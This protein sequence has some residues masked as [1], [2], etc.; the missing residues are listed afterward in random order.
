MREKMPLP[1][2]LYILAVF[3]SLLCTHCFLLGGGGVKNSGK[4]RGYKSGKVITEKSFYNVGDLPPNWRQT[5]IDSYKVLA[6]YNA[7]EKSTIETDS[8]C[9]ASY[10]DASL[11]VL[12]THLYFG[13]KDKKVRWEKNLMLDDRGALRSVAEGKV[14]GVPIVLDTVVIKK[15]SCLFDFVLVSDPDKYPEAVPDFEVFF[16]GFKYQEQP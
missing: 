13:L 4:V 12:T 3:L 7:E 6:F 11:R 8:F 9:D 14:D 16:K 2:K 15:D 10:D 5:K 1:R